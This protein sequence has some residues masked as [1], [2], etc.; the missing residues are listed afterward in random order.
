MKVGLGVTVGVVVG[1]S[2]GVEVGRLVLVGD[3]VTVTPMNCPAPHPDITKL[4]ITTI[5]IATNR[6]F[7]FIGLLHCHGCTRRLLK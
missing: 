2:V 7:V 1:V 6:C 3:G 4:I 5:K